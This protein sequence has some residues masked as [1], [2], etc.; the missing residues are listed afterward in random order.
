MAGVASLLLEAQAVTSVL[1]GQG[2][3]RLPAVVEPV[4]PAV[5]VLQPVGSLKEFHHT[6]WSAKDTWDCMVAVNGCLS[7]V[8]TSQ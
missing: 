6:I 8:C 5:V 4:A 3:Q 1:G 7:A 2:K